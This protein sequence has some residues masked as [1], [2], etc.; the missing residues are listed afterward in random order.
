MGTLA[1]SKRMT[2]GG[3]TL[4]GICPRAR[5]V[6]LT[7]CDMAADMSVPGKNVSL[8]WTKFWM[9]FDSIVL[10]PSTYWKFCS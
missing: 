9:L 3:S 5:F 7:T 2:N 6:R 10:M 1:A 4:G 8:S